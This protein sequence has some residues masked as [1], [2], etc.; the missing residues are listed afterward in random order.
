MSPSQRVWPT[1]PLERASAAPRPRSSDSTRQ[2]NRCYFFFCPSFSP[3]WS[4]GLR[5]SGQEAYGSDRRSG[6][7]GTNGVTTAL[8]SFNSQPFFFLQPCLSADPPRNQ[9]I[10]IQIHPNHQ[11]Q[12]RLLGFSPESSKVQK[13]LQKSSRKEEKKK[14]LQEVD[15]LS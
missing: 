13:L 3:I 6:L 2:T 7:E 14:L 1:P 8:L 15:K 4:H 9:F 10:R 11:L 12:F 5:S